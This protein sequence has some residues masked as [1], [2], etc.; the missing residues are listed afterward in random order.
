[1]RILDLAFKDL[2]QIL[3]DWKSGLFLV[4]MPLLF[5]LF[6][7]FVFGASDSKANVDERLPVRV[8]N[9]DGGSLAASLE[10]LLEDSEVIRPVRLDEEKAKQA[11]QMVEKGDLAAVVVIPAGYTERLLADE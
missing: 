6:F 8:I 3:R 9:Q 10:K 7:G 5:T 11:N 1:M 2:S 4:V